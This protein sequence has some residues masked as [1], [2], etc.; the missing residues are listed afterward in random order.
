M[1]RRQRV[2]LWNS[3][4]RVWRGSPWNARRSEMRVLYIDHYA[5][6]PSAGMEY[7]PH[8]MATEWR[9]LGVE[10]VL[11]AGTF[12][13]LRKV[14]FP[15]V[16]PG[17]P[18]DVDGVEFRFIRTRAYDGNGLGRVLSMIDFVSKGWVAARTI[19][20]ELRP[21][22]VIA[23]STYPFDT[24]MA[25]RI[26]RCA[27]ARLVHE[28]HDLW[29]LTPIELGGHSPR[30][31]LMWAMARAERSA[32]RRSNAIVSI[33]PNA[34]PHVR[35]LGIST[36]V[37]PIPNGIESDGP[38]EPAP[39]SFAALV[40]EA[41]A[42]GQSV[43]GYAGG[44]TNAN[45]M[46]DFVEAMGLLREEPITAVLLGDGIYRQQLEARAQQLGARIVFA[47]TVRKPEVHECLRLCDALYIGSKRSRLYEFG[48]SANKIF[49]YMAT[50]VPIINAFASDHSPLVYAGCAIR[51]EGEDPAD[52]ARAIREAA[53]LPLEE[54][55]QRGELAQE[56]VRSHHSMS[57]LARQFL[58]VLQAG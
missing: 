43:I 14:N 23:S 5:G 33:L 52:I 7:R 54:R 34:E 55:R 35:S 45:A 27:G 1:L 36:P 21:D 46:D 11:L 44:F 39:P 30:H 10:T 51:A 32:Y 3:R 38:H 57:V 48:V 19:A 25:Q 8:A 29:P 49:D 15:D 13:H 53:A 47:G 9:R 40:Q 22:A 31:P 24:W 6:S 17:A 12:S 42:G 56:W 2:V 4:R 50:G 58:D 28:I 20:R 41:R 37:I 18:V 16:R 26:A